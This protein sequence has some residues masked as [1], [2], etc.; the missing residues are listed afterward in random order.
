MVA[1]LQDG[2]FIQ[3]LRS[4]DGDNPPPSKH[5]GTIHSPK[6]HYQ[7][8]AQTRED[9]AQKKSTAAAK[10]VEF[11]HGSSAQGV[12]GCGVQWQPRDAFHLILQSQAA[13]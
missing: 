7:P 6:H 2:R 13:Q 3:K 12:Q 4:S 5:T 8:A 9:K 1:G 11:L 10:T